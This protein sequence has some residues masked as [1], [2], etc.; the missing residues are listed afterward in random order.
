MAAS[1][2]RSDQDTPLTFARVYGYAPTV[3]PLRRITGLTPGHHY[4]VFI[5]SWNA[6][7]EGKPRIA[8][9]TVVP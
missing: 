2:A 7:G 6:A 3:R 9:K 5:C 8:G 1:S 4:Q